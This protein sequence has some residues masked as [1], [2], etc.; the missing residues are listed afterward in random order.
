MTHDFSVLRTAVLELWRRGHL[1]HLP[2]RPPRRRPP[3]APPRLVEQQEGD[4]VRGE[5]SSASN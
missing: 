2:A 1:G 4:E 3:E 5:I